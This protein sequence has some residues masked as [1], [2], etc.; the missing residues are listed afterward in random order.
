MSVFRPGWLTA[1]PV[2]HRGLHNQARGIIE[3][4]ASAARAAVD[5]R[6]AIEC[7]VQISADGEAMVFHDY[8]LDRLTGETGRV[9]ARPARFLTECTLRHSADRVLT[10]HD[11]LQLIDRRVPVICEIKSRFDGDLRLAERVAAVT[12]AYAGPVALKSFDPVAMAYLHRN[13]RPL[14]IRYTPLGMVAQADYDDPADEWSVL[15][16]EA[17][18]ALANFLHYRE[19]VPDFLSYCV[20]D[21][22]DAVPFLCRSGIG[23]PLMA[24]TVRKPHQ[25]EAARQWADQVIFEGE[26]LDQ[27]ASA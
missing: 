20:D 6:Y 1:R 18:F 26:V 15:D 24:W 5:K 14:R 13:R 23:I 2:A 9:D 25:L 10:L 4:S 21:L 11:F 16:D 27:A 8:T 17:R 19:T 3:N 22:P 12:A 7:D